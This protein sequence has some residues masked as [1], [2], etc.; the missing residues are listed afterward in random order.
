VTEGDAAAPDGRAAERAARLFVGTKRRIYLTMATVSVGA[1]ITALTSPAD[2]FRERVGLALSES[3]LIA[4]I[5]AFSVDPYLKATGFSESA[6]KISESFFWE[7]VSPHCP[8]EYRAKI[9]QMAAHGLFATS[10]YTSVGFEW[11]DKNRDV[12]KLAI[13][14]DAIVRNTSTAPYRPSRKLWLLASTPGYQSVYTH[15]RVFYE[16]QNFN[17]TLDHRALETLVQIRDDG[18]LVLNERSVLQALGTGV[19]IV[20]PVDS[21][22]AEQG[23]LMYRRSGGYLP[24]LRARLLTNIFV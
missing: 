16:K 4:L 13:K 6:A 3:F 21:Y 24:L 14:M 11:A 15:W 19:P 18:A 9:K 2:S 12:L 17:W 1:G 20:D 8:A 7:S 22:T 5:L 10:V 23:G